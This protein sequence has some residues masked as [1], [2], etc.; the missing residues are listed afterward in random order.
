MN[1][2]N[3]SETILKKKAKNIEIKIKNNLSERAI[4]PTSKSPLKKTSALAKI[5]KQLC[6]HQ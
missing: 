4:S 2:N 1:I 3:N 5:Y 6:L